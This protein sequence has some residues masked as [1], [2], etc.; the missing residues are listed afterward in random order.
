[1]IDINWSTLVFQIVNFVVM[2][3]ILVRFFFKPVVKALDERARRVTSALDE[4]ARRE[5]EAEAMH[6][7]YEIKLSE[8]N[9][10]VIQMKQQ[11]QED[12][13]K[14]KQ[15]FIAQA[16][17]EIEQMRNKAHDEIENARRQAV[18]QHRLELGNLITTLS[19]RL[20]GEAG[21]DSFQQAALHEFVARLDAL[22]ADTYRERFGSIDEETITVQFVTAGPAESDEIERVRARIEALTDHPVQVRHKVNPALVAGATLRFGDTM[23]DGSLEGQL[24]G[25]RAQYIRELEQSIA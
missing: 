21:G 13:E 8:A 18:H 3:L 7:E 25:L 6:A 4:A 1:M 24:D 10:L 2:I 16:Q 17:K 22:A 23:I 15:Q 5:Q 11:A 9:E 20:I 14:T 19:A 12:L